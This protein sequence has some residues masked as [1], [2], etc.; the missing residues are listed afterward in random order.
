MIQPV[1]LG[2]PCLSSVLCSCP[3]ECRVSVRMLCFS[4][5]VLSVLSETVQTALSSCLC[6]LCSLHLV[7]LSRFSSS[8]SIVLVF[9]PSHPSLL[10]AYAVLPTPSSPQPH[11][12]PPH[13]QASQLSCSC[14]VSALSSYQTHTGVSLSPPYSSWPR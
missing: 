2:C 12:F 14:P 6:T 8:R 4:V 10:F 9:T 1:C 3:S 13:H 11:F 5:C 7:G